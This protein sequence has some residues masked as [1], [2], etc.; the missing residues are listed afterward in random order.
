MNKIFIPVLILLGTTGCATDYVNLKNELSPVPAQIY[1]APP[2]TYYAPKKV[3]YVL[4]QERVM[5]GI[6]YYKH[7]NYSTCVNYFNDLT[8]RYSLYITREQMETIN[9]YISAS[10]YLLGEFEQSKIYWQRMLD[11]NPGFTADLNIFPRGMVNYLNRNY[12]R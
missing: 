10:Y 1:T 5:E 6:N 8:N 4:K 9:L 3:R 12:R 7:F 2:P 11:T